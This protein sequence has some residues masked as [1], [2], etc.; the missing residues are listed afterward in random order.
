MKLRTPLVLILLLGISA[1]V[2]AQDPSGPHPKKVRTLED[3]Q[4]R[5][6]KEV[7]TVSPSS[8]TLGNK[9][10]TMLVS[11]DLFPSKVTASYMGSRRKIPQLKKEVL[12]Q[13]ARLYAG[14]MEGYT[15]PY[16]TEMLFMENG[17]KY[18]LAVKKE[19][20]PQISQLK[21]GAPLD[22]YLVRVGTAKISDKWEAM[23]L[24]ENY[25]SVKGS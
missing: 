5:T 18:W 20:V 16:Q 3:Y 25:V 4:A 21:R 11:A 2:H 23:V 17:T 22:L 13:W 10:E 9:L 12:R 15:E 8:E 14:V 24:V 19:L 6:L 7:T 1:S